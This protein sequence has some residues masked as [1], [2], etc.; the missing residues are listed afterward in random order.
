MSIEELAQKT[1][2]QYGKRATYDHVY[3]IMSENGVRD[4]DGDIA[5]RVIELVGTAIIRTN[6]KVVN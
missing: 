1:A 5:G 4:E 6:I 2:I 3:R